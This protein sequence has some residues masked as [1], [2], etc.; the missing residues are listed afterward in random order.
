MEIIFL[1]IGLIIGLVVGYFLRIKADNKT[2][3]NTELEQLKKQYEEQIIVRSNAEG[4]LQALENE[5]VGVKKER[6]DI[7][8]DR[9]KL[10]ERVAAAL[11]KFK[12]QEDKII[13]QKNYINEV[14][15]QFQKDFQLIASKIVKDN[16]EEMSKLN[17]QRLEATLKPLG[18]TIKSFE[19][20]ISKSSAENNTLKGEI[21]KLVELNQHMAKEAQNLTKALKGDTKQQGNWGELILEKIL[22]NSG[23]E[24]GREYETQYSTTNEEGNRLF[25]DVIVHLPE[26]KKII[27]DSKVSLIA[28]E[29]Y[30]S[31]EEKTEKETHLKNHLL[32]VKNQIKNLSEKNYQ[33]TLAGQSVDF[34]LMFMPIESAFA[35]ALQNDATIFESAWEKKIVIV[36]PTTLLATLRTI[37]SIWKQERQTKNAIE[38]ARQGGLLYEKFVG[39]VDDLEKVGSQLQTTQKTYDAAFNKLKDGK[40][41]L[42]SRAEKLRELGVQTS[43]SI[44]ERHKE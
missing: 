33:S 16:S 1:V 18:E 27:I 14:Q 17:S 8:I 6:D 25:L 23:L 38:I 7:R 11:E 28:Y 31:A 21:S 13:E 32:A 37:S 44:D 39:F 20:K 42:I 34:V 15:L 30:I 36:S 24:K 41:N 9:D 3:D 2:H 40:G 19:E 4:R 5:I 35:L 26:N 29:Q 10:S 22:E 12:L 43:K